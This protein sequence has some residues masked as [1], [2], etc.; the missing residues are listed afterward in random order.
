MCVFF[1]NFDFFCLFERKQI[2]W[3]FFSFHLRL[4]GRLTTSNMSTY[5]RGRGPMMQRICDNAASR[6]ATILPTTQSSYQHS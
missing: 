2:V 6:V 3:V 1:K 4:A 5:R